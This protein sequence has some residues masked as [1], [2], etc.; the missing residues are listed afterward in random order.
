MTE[1][2]INASISTTTG[3]APF[4]LNAGYMPSMIREFH[5]EQK[6][7]KALK[8]FANQA[9]MNLAEAH[10]VLIEARVFQTKRANEHRQAEPDIQAGDLVYLS[11]KNLN[12]SKGRAR[13]LCL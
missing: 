5:K 7:P 9:L 13:K 10:N 3:F 11:T 8:D 1:F 2:A 12:L 6:L 4:E